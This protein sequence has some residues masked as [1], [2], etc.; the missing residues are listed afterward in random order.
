MR[1]PPNVRLALGPSRLACAAIACIALGAA[2]VV[3]LLPLEVALIGLAWCGLAA[4]A[5]DRI[6]VVGLRRGPRAIRE[7]T[8]SGDRLIV[9]RTGDERVRAGYVCAST[10][11]GANLTTIVW[12]PDRAWRARAFVIVPDMV[13]ADAFRRLRTL[14]RYSREQKTGVQPT[15][16]P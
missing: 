9:V 16:S 6:V 4:W 15:G 11:V 3:A 7:I 10:Y 12:K 8:L 1:L 5:I 14:L 2:T 13:D